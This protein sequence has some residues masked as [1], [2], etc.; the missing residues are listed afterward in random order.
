[1]G[2]GR[3]PWWTAGVLQV[4]AFEP[5][6]LVNGPGLRAVLWV[7]GCGRRCPG[8]WNPAF[9]PRQGG[10]T[11]AVDEVLGWIRAAVAAEVPRLPSE[12]P[13]PEMS[14]LTSAAT[15]ANGATA[16]ATHHPA[17]IIHQPSSPLEGISFSGG[18][19]FDQAAALAVVARG[20]REMGLGVLIFTGHPWEDLQHSADP[21]ERA[22]LE[23]ADLLVAGPYE[24]DQ[25]GTHP[26]LSSANQRLVFLTD[27]YR[28]H[29]FGRRRRMEYRIAPDGT[30]RATGFPPTNPP[31]HLHER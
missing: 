3:S 21:G 28:G 23:A 8:C 20:A 1:M 31:I 25:P 12:I 30:V 24:R 7:Q 18:E 6:S 17:S 9:L 29:D 14:L 16:P 19:P 5:R 27:R 15:E 13:K 4:A 2:G 10:R 11:V 22:L 26:L